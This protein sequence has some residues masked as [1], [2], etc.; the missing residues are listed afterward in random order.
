MATR[1]GHLSILEL[2]QELRIRLE[3]CESEDA[4]GLQDE[5]WRCVQ[6]NGFTLFQSTDVRHRKSR[7]LSSD[8]VRGPK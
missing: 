3:V 5:E 6:I 1:A 8:E 4:R 2:I 7:A